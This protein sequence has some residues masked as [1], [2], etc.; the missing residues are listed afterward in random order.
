[1]PV[2]RKR[3]KAEQEE[4]DT[5]SMSDESVES[6]VSQQDNK[7]GNGYWTLYEILQ[8][9]QSSSFQQSG[10]DD[11]A[12]APEKTR[13]IDVQDRLARRAGCLPSQLPVVSTECLPHSSL[14]D[15]LQSFAASNPRAM[16]CLD[17]TAL[18]AFG[19]IVEQL[20]ASHVD[21]GLLQFLTSEE[22]LNTAGNSD[23]SVPETI[24]VRVSD[25]TG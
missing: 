17:E 23:E 11:E 6:T 14:L 9:N 21:E 2:L 13:T 7:E 25:V 15:A 4:E 12:E 24:L 10:E 16:P 20:A 1:M 8:Y 19:I 22:P 5:T 18:L 3:V